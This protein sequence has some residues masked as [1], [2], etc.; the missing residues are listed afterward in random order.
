MSLIA[1]TLTLGRAIA[2]PETV[3]FFAQQSVSNLTLTGS[4]PGNLTLETAVG[5][6]A[7]AL[8]MLS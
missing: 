3:Y 6:L 7:G 4:T 1:S 2:G 8:K 5:R